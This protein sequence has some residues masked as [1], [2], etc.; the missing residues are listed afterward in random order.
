MALLLAGAGAGARFLLL[1]LHA[2]MMPW[3]L[4]GVAAFL[5]ERACGGTLV[6]APNWFCIT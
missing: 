6:E 4:T 3:E 5:R 1:C 2:A